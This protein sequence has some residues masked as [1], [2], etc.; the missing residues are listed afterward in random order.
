VSPLA[1][2][3]IQ[4]V[5]TLAGV[6]ALAAVLLYGARRAGVGRPSGPLSLLGRLPL[7]ARR[8]VYLVRV[9]TTIYVVGSSEAGLVKL[10]EVSEQSLDDP[11]PPENPRGG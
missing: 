9:G 11:P 10:G 5:V 4:T 7:D 3:L 6:V 1:S 8:A 2:Y